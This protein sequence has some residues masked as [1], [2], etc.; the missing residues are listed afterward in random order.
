M[1]GTLRRKERSRPVAASRRRRA[2]REPVSRER[3][4]RVAVALADAGG[5]SQLTMRRLAEELGVEAMSLYHHVS[6]KDAIVDAMVESVFRELEPPSNAIGWKEAMRRRA[7]SMRATLL[8]HPWAIGVMSSRAAS[9][10]LARFD[11]SP[12]RLRE[13]GFSRSLAAHAYAV[14]DGYLYGFLQLERGGASADQFDFGLELILDGLER[15]LLEER[16]GVA[17][18]GGA[19]AGPVGP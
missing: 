8:R 10:K 12:D 13:S 2:A 14:L 4:I 3:A 7:R 18:N 15:K 19:V 9:A 16:S 1:D 17:A 6:N 5:L 11:A